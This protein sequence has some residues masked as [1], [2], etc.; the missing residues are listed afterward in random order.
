VHVEHSFYSSRWYRTF[1]GY[2]H[3]AYIQPVE[4]HS[5]IP[6]PR[7]R[8]GG[9]IGEVTVPMSQ[10]KRLYRRNGW[11]NL[12]RL[13]YQS[14]HWV[15][16]VI[17]GPTGKPWYEITDERLKI[18]YHVPASHI[19][20]IP[21]Y[22]LTPLSPEVPL[23]DK[24]IVISNRE[25]TMQCYEGEKL[26]F[27]TDVSTGE[28]GPTQNGIARITPRGK[29]RISWKM[30]VRHMGN[31]RITDDFLSYEL[32][33]VPWCCFF[34]S[35]GVA[36]HGTFWHNNYGYKMSSGCVNLRSDEAKWLYRW[37]MPVSPPGEWYQDGVGTEVQ[38]IDG[39]TY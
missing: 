5:N 19:R 36:F 18:K 39:D 35:T 23:E 28:G 37:T 38:V 7:I 13:Y 2:I 1:D 29:F 8:E 12:Y 32:V 24:R 22:E 6:A 34:V 14:V 30:P 15:T 10:S 4:M 3:G 26:V 16:D 20:L 27:A 17:E 25:Q 31:G 33:G 9:Q 11:R 21:D